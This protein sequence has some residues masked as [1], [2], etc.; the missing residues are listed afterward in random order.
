MENIRINIVFQALTRPPMMLGVTVDYFMIML[1]ALLILFMQFSQPAV[2]LLWLPLHMVGWVLCK[3][4]PFIFNVL[5]KKIDFIA[6]P[7]KK[8]WGCK[9]Y[10]PN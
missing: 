5:F 9:S 8:L 2:L 7:N 6:T 4:D 3:I 10:A 1:I